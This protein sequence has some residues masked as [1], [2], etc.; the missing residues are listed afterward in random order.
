MKVNSF[1]TLEQRLFIIS[2]TIRNIDRFFVHWEDSVI[3]QEELP[4]ITSSF[5][6]LAV[7]KESSYDFTLLMW[8]LIGGFRNGHTF[9]FD[10]TILPPNGYFNFNLEPNSNS[11]TVKNSYDENLTNGDLIISI[12][13]KPL[14]DWYGEIGKYIGAKKEISRKIKAGQM[15]SFILKDKNSEIQYMDS[16]GTIRSNRIHWLDTNQHQENIK[17][18]S[19]VNTEGRWIREN[20]VAYIN[21]PSFIHPRFEE[22]AI[23]LVH[24]FDEA[25]SLIVDLRGNGGGNTPHHLIDILMDRH[26]YSWMD[27]S[28]HPEWMYKR[29]G[30]EPISFQENFRYTICGPFEQT[31]KNLEESYKGQII[32]LIDKYTGSAAEDFV[33]P[34]KYNNRGI[35]IG[36]DTYGSTGQPEYV[37]LG[38]DKGLGIGS[39]RTFFPNGEQFEGIG[40]QPD[41]KV[42][43]TREDVYNKTDSVIQ[44]ALDILQ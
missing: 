32:L 34:F 22:E 36:E 37:N 16:N 14:N 6:E 41:I 28:R 29:Y 40:I 9:Y 4:S 13:G 10:R 33:M 26:Y 30:N 21:I 24:Q 5:F 3:T 43:L 25:E 12:D 35:I 7:G 2:E 8:E 27:R 39:I 18:K 1:L 19:S 42:C 17:R 44:T 20:K 38:K 15:L 23:R 31:P 11:W